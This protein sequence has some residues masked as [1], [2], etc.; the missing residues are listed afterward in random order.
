MLESY[1]AFLNQSKRNGFMT[2][3]IEMTVKNAICIFEDV[4]GLGT[5]CFR[6]VQ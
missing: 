6:K 4:D 2:Q 3:Y 5:H 1:Y